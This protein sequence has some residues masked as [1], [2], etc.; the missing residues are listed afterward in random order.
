MPNIQNIGS[1]IKS[2]Y[3]IGYV[4]LVQLFFKK[5]L[6]IDLKHLGNKLYTSIV[7][8]FNQFSSF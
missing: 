4:C 6:F 2:G 5:F 1:L 8:D 7:Y 3:K